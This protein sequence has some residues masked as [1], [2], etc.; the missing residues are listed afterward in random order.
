PS[1]GA[2]VEQVGDDTLADSF[3]DVFF[4]ILGGP[5]P[6]YNH[7]ALTIE[8]VIDRV[9]PFNTTY[10]HPIAICIDLF[11]D[12]IA[13]SDTGINLVEAE[14]NT[15]PTSGGGIAQPIALGSDS[16]AET[17]A[18]GSSRDYTAPIAAAGVLGALAVAAGGWYVRRRLQ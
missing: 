6:M 3:F 15:G 11:D 5:G 18:P 8:A 13:G 7:D 14:H 17:S 2:I 9:P 1:L 16:A 10:L 4:E 12:P